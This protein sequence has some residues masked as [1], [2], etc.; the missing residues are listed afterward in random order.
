MGLLTW[1][2]RDTAKADWDREVRSVKYELQTQRTAAEALQQ[3]LVH[4]ERECAQVS[5][6]MQAEIQVWPHWLSC[7]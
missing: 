4:K 5:A 2:E 6:A 7:D 3:A 1:Q